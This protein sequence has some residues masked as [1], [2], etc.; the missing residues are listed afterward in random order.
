MLNPADP[1][2]FFRWSFKILCAAFAIVFSPFVDVCKR[3]F[4]Q[5][6]R[7]VKCNRNVAISRVIFSGN[8]IV[9]TGT[10]LIG[11]PKMIIGD[12]FYVNAY[13]H[14]LGE[15]YIGNDVQIGPQTVIWGRNHRFSK[16]KR[17]R[18]QGHRTS[19]VVIGNDVWIG[20]HCTILC[21][22]VIGDGAVIGAGSIVCK[23]VP[24]GTIVIGDRSL[25]MEDRR[26]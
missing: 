22:V 6:K 21:G 26:A 10:R 15:I 14:F 11:V 8:A 16:G 9:D 17:I 20:A 13:C 3:R 5:K 25:T 4:A 24:P 7:N 1:A 23:D 18:E 2:V 12:N 19:A